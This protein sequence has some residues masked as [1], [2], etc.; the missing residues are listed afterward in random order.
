M[1][2]EMKVKYLFVE[3]VYPTYVKLQVT[4]FLVWLTASPICF[5]FLNDSQLPYAEHYWWACIAIAVLEAA[6]AY[7]AI[8]KSK[9]NFSPIAAESS[10]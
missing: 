9:R 2:Q 10:A 5:L 7:I 6:E 8:K 4:L 1:Y 3:L